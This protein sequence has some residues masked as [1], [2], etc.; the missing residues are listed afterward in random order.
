MPEDVFEDIVEVVGGDVVPEAV[1]DDKVLTLDVVFV[2]I[3]DVVLLIVMEVVEGL[4][5]VIWENRKVP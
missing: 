4:E 5:D 2:I 1:L 3:L